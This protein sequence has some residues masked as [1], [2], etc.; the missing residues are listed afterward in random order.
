MHVA[1]SDIKLDEVKVDYV[2]VLGSRAN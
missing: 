2:P 1:T